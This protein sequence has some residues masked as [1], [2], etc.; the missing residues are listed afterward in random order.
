M[1]YCKKGVKADFVLIKFKNDIC[2]VTQLLSD[3]DN[4]G[5]YAITYLRKFEKLG[6]CFVFPVKSDIHSVNEID[7]ILVLPSPINQT[8]KQLSGLLKFNISFNS[9]NVR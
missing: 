5:D 3:I 4:S 9:Y 7:I 2:Y 6:S 1:D 8:T